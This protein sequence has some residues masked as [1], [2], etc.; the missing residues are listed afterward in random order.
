MKTYEHVKITEEPYNGGGTRKVHEHPAFGSIRISRRSGHANLFNSDFHH[1]HFISVTI[2]RAKLFRDLSSDTVY[3]SNRDELVEVYLSEAQ[4]ATAIT[5]MNMGCG[6]PCTINSFN[7]ESVPG[8][9]E[10]P[11]R[12][13]QFSNELLDRLDRAKAMLSETA[14]AIGAAGLSKKK[15]AELLSLIGRVSADI[16]SNLDFV[17]EQFDEHMEK[18]VEDARAEIAG[19]AMAAMN[20]LAMSAVASSGGLTIPVEAVAPRL[21]IDHKEA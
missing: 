11:S 12:R 5:S 20:A 10:P 4:F 13:D 21:A 15:E 1:Q 3:N 2:S 7:R 8:I 9:E 14:A 17:A 19:T 16:G 18:T 6:S